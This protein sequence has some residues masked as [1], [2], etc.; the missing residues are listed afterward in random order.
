VGGSGV[1]QPAVNNGLANGTDI[2]NLVRFTISPPHIG[3]GHIHGFVLLRIDSVVSTPIVGRLLIRNLRTNVA[4]LLSPQPAGLFLGVPFVD[5]VMGPNSTANIGF[6]FKRVG[7]HMLTA[8]D[9]A[10][11][12]SDLQLIAGLS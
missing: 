6:S 4:T 7:N 2:T 11:M 10:I 5:V 3:S 12:L 1:A 9:I 8:A